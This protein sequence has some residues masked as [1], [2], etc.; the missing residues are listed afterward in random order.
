MEC[1][2]LGAVVVMFVNGRRRKCVSD[3]GKKKRKRKVVFDS[4]VLEADVYFNGDVKNS[5]RLFKD[6]RVFPVSNF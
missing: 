5:S 6:L 2:T 3:E 1:V 4:Q